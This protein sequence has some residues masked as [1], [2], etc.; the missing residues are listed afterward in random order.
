MKAQMG[1]RS[2]APLFLKPPLTST[3]DGVGVQ[4]HAP[5]ALAPE[6]RRSTHCTR[7]WVGSRAG[8]NGWGKSRPIG[9]RS[10][11]PPARSESL[12]RLGYSGPQL[13]APIKKFKLLTCLQA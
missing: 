4:C 7:G 11:D 12:Y 3:L 8:L 5:A 13:S 9:S 2:I 1:I 10:R 6:T